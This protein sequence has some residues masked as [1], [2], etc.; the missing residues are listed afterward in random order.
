MPIK[1]APG[2]LSF[3]AEPVK[4]AA[5]PA[6]VDTPEVE[7]GVVELE[8]L[9]EEGNELLALAAEALRGLVA[10]LATS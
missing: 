10:V 1:M 8:G 5:A 7:V 4:V 9:L 6:L 2:T 3:V